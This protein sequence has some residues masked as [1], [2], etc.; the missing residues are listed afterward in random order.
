M[1]EHLYDRGVRAID[2][3]LCHANGIAWRRDRKRLHQLHLCLALYLSP[4]RA[5]PFSPA[6]QRASTSRSLARATDDA[7]ESSLYMV[8]PSPS[9]RRPVNGRDSLFADGIS[10]ADGRTDGRSTATER[11]RERR[12]RRP[13]VVEIPRTSR[14]TLG[15]RLPVPQ[16]RTR[17]AMQFPGV[18]SPT[19]GI[20]R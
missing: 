17:R 20:A 18:D 1:I 16:V 6:A 11:G 8:G 3:P 19:S 9:G 13:A 2:G 12:V 14:E 15:E 5:S 4:S 10:Q 7:S